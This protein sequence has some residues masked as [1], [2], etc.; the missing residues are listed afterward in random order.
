VRCTIAPLRYGAGIKGKVLTS[1][2]HAVPCVMSPVAAEGIALPEALR[3]LVAHSDA[4]AAAKVVALH[5]DDALAE[6]MGDASLAFVEEE[7]GAEAVARRLAA[8][9]TSGPAET[10]IAEVP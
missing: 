8:A 7:F 5:R 3:W 2:A 4:D 10:A 6:R 9:V 1:M